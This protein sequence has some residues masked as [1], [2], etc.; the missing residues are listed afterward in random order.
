MGF[1]HGHPDISG[2][3]LWGISDKSSDHQLGAAENMSLRE[4]LAEL[5]TTLDGQRMWHLRASLPRAV[6]NLSIG[7]FRDKRGSLRT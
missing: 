2:L 3:D 1:W 4:Y 7:V 5:E 6:L